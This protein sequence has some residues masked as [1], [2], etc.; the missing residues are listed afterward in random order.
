MT[1]SDIE[2]NDLSWWHLKLLI[3]TSLQVLVQQS[4]QLLVLLVQQ[5]SLL[6]Q[7]LSVDKKLIVLAQ[8]V[9]KCFPNRELLIGEDLG[10]RG[11]V[12]ALLLLLSAGIARLIC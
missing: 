2:A 5:A 11:P 3:N 1:E 4:L 9:V 12:H 10:H 6:N 8:R 7:V